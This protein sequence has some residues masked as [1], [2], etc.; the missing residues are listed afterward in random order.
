MLAAAAVRLS[1]GPATP[2]E[3]LFDIVVLSTPGRVESVLISLLRH[4][5]KP[6]LLAGSAAVILVTCAATGAILQGLESRR[7][8]RARY[9]RLLVLGTAPFILGGLVLSP[10]LRDSGLLQAMASLAGAQ[11]AFL[12]A[13]TL[14]RLGRVPDAAPAG[15]P[16]SRRTLLRTAARLTFLAATG[17]LGA[18][19]ARGLLARLRGLP[20]DV[21]AVRQ[22]LA[23]EGIFRRPELADLVSQE[24]TPTPRFYRVS[25]NALDPEIGRSGWRLTVGGLVSR[26][27][28]LSRDDL[29]RL[30]RLERY[31]TLMC[32]SNE[33]GDGLI[34][35]ASWVGVRL[36]DVLELA[37]VSA[38]VRY[39]VFRCADGYVESIALDQARETFLAYGMNSAPLEHR[40]GFPLRA[41]VPGTY[42]MKNPKWITHIEAAASPE[43]GFW[44]KLGWKA[45]APPKIFSRIDVPKARAVVTAGQ[46]MLGGIAFS[47]NRGIA[48]VEVSDDEGRTWQD[49]QLRQSLSPNSW[50]L[51]ALP[52]TPRN[53]GEH[54]LI[55]RAT[56]GLRAVQSAEIQPP[57]PSGVSGYHRIIVTTEVE[58]R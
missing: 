52:W 12:G 56:D 31:H 42:G 28:R 30:T 14:W 32:I 6:I 9:G 13:L 3:L 8:R 36:R 57:F 54:V 18:L 26:P 19:A 25:K 22:P 41:L 10:A 39:I 55:V 4:A 47:G 38:H 17:T 24:V 35:N 20:V 29:D 48:S 37:Q 49:A 51:W 40:H 2:P 45:G 50:V 53:V 27:L 58:K 44:N 46:V 7:S 16:V 11:L 33:I 23:P 1:G 43:Q 34:G 15:R 5:A 21:T